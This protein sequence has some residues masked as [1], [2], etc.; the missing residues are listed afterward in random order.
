MLMQAW[1][2]A[3]ALATG[4][5]VVMK[6]AEQT[7][8]S[9][10]RIGELIV[11]A[12]FPGGRREPAARI[13]PHRRRGHRPPHGRGQSGV[14]RLDRG[15][16]SDHGSRR[17]VQSEAGHSGAGRKEPEHRIR[18][19]RSGRSGGGRALR[20]CSSTTANAVAPDRGYSSKRKSTTSSWRRAAPAPGSV[21]VGD[22]FDPEDGTGPAGGSSA[23]RQSHG[24]YRIGAERG[25]HAGVRRRARREIAATSSS[26][27]SSPMFRTT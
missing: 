15:R 10:L 7:P 5:T 14:H 6:P 26:R 20:D 11:E 1:K 17:E 8:L 19:H 27:Q 3:P 13:R 21:R 25:R 16:A 9:A 12:G 24:L 2:L 22:P 4:N 23:V 18:G